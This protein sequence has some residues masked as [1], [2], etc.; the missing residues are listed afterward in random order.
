MRW[1]EGSGRDFGVLGE[2]L[3]HK[4]LQV[5][6][7]LWGELQTASGGVPTPGEQDPLV[8]RRIDC[9]T[10]I[11]LE[12]RSPRA[13]EQSV[14][15]PSQAE[16]GPAEPL[17]QFRSDQADRS[18]SCGVRRMNIHRPRGQLS[19]GRGIVQ[20]LIGF[21]PQ[22]SALDVQLV[23]GRGQFA[24]LGWIALAETASCQIGLSHPRAGVEPRPDLP[25][26]L[27]EVGRPLRPDRFAQCGI[28]RRYRIGVVRH[29]DTGANK[30]PVEGLVEPHLVAC[31]THRRE[32]R[33][34]LPQTYGL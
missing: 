34:T 11:K 17:D 7:A 9:G 27:V 31:R 5:F 12:R 6:H 20:F 16:R 28:A 32:Q 8:P 26:P 22:F 21:G 3:I 19:H 14:F 2:P 30:G 24:R 4:V 13:D 1:L 23:Q 10:N 33:D 29:P 25:T 18:G 15:A